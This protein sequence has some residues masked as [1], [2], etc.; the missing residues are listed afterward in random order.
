MNTEFRRALMPQELRSLVLF[1]H[2]VFSRHPADWFDRDDWE[3]YDS[4]WMILDNRKVGCCAFVPHVDF[5]EDFRKDEKN[6]RRR[7][8]L[9]IVTTGILP[10]LR[11]L[12]LGELLKRWQVSYARLHGFT[13]IITNT[14]ESNKT[15]INLNK[16][17]GFKVVR[18]TPDYYEQ[19]REPTVVME[20]R[21]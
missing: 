18:T 7:A 20:L 16:K 21:F 8:S 19:P 17:V 15:M 6:P 13:R 14:R 1:D 10:S 11:G 4:W 9:Y 3:T 5:Q 12:G 2:K